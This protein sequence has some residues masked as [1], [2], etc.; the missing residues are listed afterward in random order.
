MAHPSPDARAGCLA[1]RH[2]GLLTRAD[3]LAAGFSVDQIRH[4]LATGRWQRVG[5]SVFQITGAPTTHVQRTLAACWSGPA[6][7]VASHL[8][9]A[10]LFDLAPAPS[11]PHLSVPPTASA[12]TPGVTTHRTT[13]AARDR[14]HVGV[15][16][17]TS[18]A[19]TLVDCATVVPT[20]PL[21]DLVD[22]A[23]VRQLTTVRR[24]RGAMVRAS[25]RP[26]R[27]G[28]PALELMLAVWN[29]T[30]TPGS[31]AEMRLVR[32][33]AE[34]GFPPPVHQHTVSAPSGRPL[35]RIDL[36][37]P[38]WRTGLEYDGQRYPT[39]RRLAHD[40]RRHAQIMAAGWRLY[41]SDRFDL[42]PSSDRLRR[43]L[44]AVFHSR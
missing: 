37:W 1:A 9:A 18:V 27:K 2:H 24:I 8:S 7:A 28:L 10:N 25:E 29:D 23:L 39:P 17:S 42:R 21:A 44:A 16:P 6:G 43:E 13:L 19:R 4:R 15:I 11:I 14:T 35:G 22:D 38:Q 41:Q 5:R 26:G 33:L 12:R 36:A 32:R 31:A 20:E 3:A 34:W 30:I 40:E